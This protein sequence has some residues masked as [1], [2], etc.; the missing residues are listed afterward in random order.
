MKIVDKIARRKE[1]M[2]EKARIISYNSNI[3]IV[4]ITMSFWNEDVNLICI[5][6]KL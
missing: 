1:S 3:Y 4:T 5:E 2:G 6:N